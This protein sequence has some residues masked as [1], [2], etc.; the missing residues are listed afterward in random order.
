MKK[1]IVFL[2]ISGIGWICDF[3]T[4]SLL[5]GFF[6]VQVFWANFISSY[7]GVT[8]VWFVSLRRVFGGLGSSRGRYLYIYWFYQLL[9]IL[10]YSKIVSVCAVYLQLWILFEMLPGQ[11]SMLAKILVTPFNLV[12]NF[13]FMR[14]LV[15]FM[16]N[17]TKN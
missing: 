6:D 8:F 1:F 11:W 3:G 17:L 2:L 14:Y 13:V 9:S 4:F 16:N 5:V 15:R 10:A 7:V 12:T